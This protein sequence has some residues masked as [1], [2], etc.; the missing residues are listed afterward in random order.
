MPRL[1]EQK[2][3]KGGNVQA[4]KSPSESEQNVLGHFVET[5]R[6]PPD[7]E[8]AEALAALGDALS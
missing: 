5:G 4:W 8:L 3:D 7:T 2:G 6:A 1:F